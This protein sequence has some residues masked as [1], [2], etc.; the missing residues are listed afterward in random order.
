MITGNTS[1]LKTAQLK[2]LER[3]AGRRVNP[4]M[5]VSPELAKELCAVAFEL[6]RQ[7]GV[8]LSRSGQVE[9]VMVGDHRS[10][11]IPALKQFRT[12]GGRLK[13]LRCVHTHLAG[14][15]LSEDD[16]M[17]LLFLRLDMMTVVKMDQG[18]AT[19]L[20][21]AHLAPQ[22]VDGRNWI[23]LEP[24]IPSQQGRSCRELIAALEDEFAKARPVREIDAGRDRAILIS[25]TP[26]SKVRAQESM[27]E[28]VELAR[29]A[30]VIILD[31]V[32]QRREKINPRL[33][34]GKG[35]LGEIMLTALK[36]NANLLIFDQELN[37]SQVRSITDHTELR[38]I[39]R[40]Q[41]ILDIF[42]RRAL[43]REGKLQ[44]EMAQLKYMLPR[45]TTRD[46]ALSRL[47]GGIGGRGPGETRLEVDRRRINDRLGKLGKK[48]KE[49]GREREQRRAR[50]RKNDLPVLSL[51]GY[52]NAGKSTLLN[53]LTKS[54]IVAED[55]L[56]ATLDPTSR[57]LRFPED[58]EVIITDTVGFIRNLPEDL[59]KAFKSTL[60][61]LHEADV[62][63]HV[64]DISNPRCDDHIQVVEDLLRELEL[65]G[66]P[67]LKV[68][69]KIDLV[70]PEVVAE[71]L[72]LHE[73]V[74]VSARD[75]ATLGPFLDRARSLVLKK[76]QK[77]GGYAQ[78]EIEE[79]APDTH[80][81]SPI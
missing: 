21:S 76:W 70:A 80:V 68:F 31:T 23:L 37:P 78:P 29:S 53:T 6:G 44:I 10:I 20:H 57:R 36:L 8:L 1:G 72:R 17:D 63:V 12:S 65:D 64:I 67:C 46:D 52:T 25:V 55:K 13:G 40:T 22:T 38:V 15:D 59:L 27:D 16:L 34:L 2:G 43:S 19:W 79:S 50:R 3:I 75:A 74:A 11:M 4:D 69:N 77:R 24:E 81:Y 73:A 45:L 28:L 60:E 5:V 42:A 26:L 39:D 30:E 62:L 7:V 14:E 32:V 35:K 49:V 47:T 56:F 48:L 18:G 71:Q 9:A 66:L 33:I 41:L 54:A 61:E 51:V 58:V